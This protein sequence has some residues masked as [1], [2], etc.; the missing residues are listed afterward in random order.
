MLR[1]ED[2]KYSVDY[3]CKQPG[4]KRKTTATKP[5]LRGI[6]GEVHPGSVL[7]IMGSSGAGKTT[8]L[9]MLAG[10]LSAAGNGRAEG[11]IFINGKKRDYRR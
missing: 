11:R 7:A 1:F 10:R 2:I 9:N 3:K 8:L 5:I 4:V 6:S